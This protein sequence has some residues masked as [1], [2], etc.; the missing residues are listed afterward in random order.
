[1]RE[2]ISNPTM[3]DIIDKTYSSMINNKYTDLH[4]ISMRI[5]ELEEGEMEYADIKKELTSV[6]DIFDSIIASK[7]L[8]RRQVETIVDKIIVYED[9]GLDIFLKGNLHELCTNYI[10]FKS[11]NKE[12]IVSAIIKYA[13]THKDCVMKKKCE[14]YIRTQGFKFDTNTFS[15]LYDRL[16]EYGYIIQISERKGCYVKD[17]GL[18]QQAMRDDNVMA[19]TT[20]CQKNIVTLQFLRKIYQWH[21][22]FKPKFKKF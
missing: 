11:S 10:Q 13:E 22:A 1:M 4:S 19:Y 15:K 6:L 8:S 17:I 14:K 2:I 20:R 12:Q 5:E 16:I 3:K 21:M 7:S 9:D 18:L